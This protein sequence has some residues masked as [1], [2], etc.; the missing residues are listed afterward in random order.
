LT[1]AAATLAACGGSGGGPS[2]GPRDPRTIDATPSLSFGPSTLTVN[3]GD[4]VTFAFGS[5]AHNVFFDAEA[6]A[7]ADI[8]GLNANVSV[9]RTFTTAGSFHYT[10]HI[11]PGMAGTVVVR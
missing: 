1:L 4:E 11:H 10:C 2:T 9:R 6:G 7:P 5:L 8:T 3:V